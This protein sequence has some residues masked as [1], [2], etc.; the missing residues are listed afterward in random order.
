MTFHDSDSWNSRVR[1][2]GM[3]HSS[4]V[5]LINKEY[6]HMFAAPEIEQRKAAKPG[7][8]IIAG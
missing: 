7:S 5:Q 3:V 6:T 4:I 1:A 2:L 8:E